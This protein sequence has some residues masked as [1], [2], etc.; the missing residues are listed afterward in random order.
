MD[1]EAPSPGVEKLIIKKDFFIKSR[2]EDIRNY[3]EFSPKVNHTPSRFWEEELMEWST[4][5]G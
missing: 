3:Y 5:P 1:S 4:R 2:K